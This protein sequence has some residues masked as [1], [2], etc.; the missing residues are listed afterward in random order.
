M[1]SPITIQGELR[2]PQ[3]FMHDK[4]MH[5]IERSLQGYGLLPMHAQERRW[6]LDHEHPGG[7]VLTF[8]CALVPLP[9]EP[10]L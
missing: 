5:E 9:E 4:H 7:Y 10:A 6:R 1:A 2:L 3:A 8:T